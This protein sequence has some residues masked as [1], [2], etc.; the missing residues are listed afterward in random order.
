MSPAP[1]TNKTLR[2]FVCSWSKNTNSWIYIPK[3]DNLKICYSSHSFSLLFFEFGIFKKLFFT[4]SL[5]VKV[6]TIYTGH[7]YP[8]SNSLNPSQTLPPYP[9]PSSMPCYFVVCNTRSPI[10]YSYCELVC[11][12]VM[13]YPEDTAAQKSAPANL[14]LF[15]LFWSLFLTVL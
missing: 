13:S 10:S 1:S 3:T 6:Y 8:L 4:Y 12:M 11:I 14:W 2:M 15:S 5:K 9:L 7:L